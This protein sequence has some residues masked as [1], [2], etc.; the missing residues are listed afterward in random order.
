M[1]AVISLAVI[2]WLFGAVSSITDVLLFFVPKTLT[3]SQGGTGPVH[4]YWSLAAV[5]LAATLL[6]IVGRIA[7]HY[8]I[9]RMIALFDAWM[10][11]VPLLRKLYGTIRQVNATASDPTKSAF[12]QVVMVPYP[13]EGLY[14]IAFVTSDEH[15]EVEARLDQDLLGVFVATTPNP[16]TGFLLVVPRDQVVPLDMTVGQ[17]VKY[18]ISVGAL[19]PDYRPPAPPD[20]RESPVAL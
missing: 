3:H 7:S 1:P 16:A 18:I 19:V 9:R 8:F 5:A 17:G 6:T 12:K 10:L 2:R 14:T 11:Q 13:R 20:P 15:P 4:W